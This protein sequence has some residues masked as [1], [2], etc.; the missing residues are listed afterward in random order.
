MSSNDASLEVLSK[1]A[2]AF[3]PGVSVDCVIFGFHDG[4]MKVL[5]NRFSGYDKWMIPGGFVFKDE[6]VDKAA[7]RILAGRTGLEDIYLRQF[8]FFGNSNR[9]DIDENKDMLIKLGQ[10]PPDI[11]GDTHWLLNRFISAGYYAL[12]EYSKVRIHT[13]PSEEIEWFAMDEIPVLYSDH[14]KIIDKAISTIRPQLSSI[15]VGYELLPE[16][17][18][19]SELRII[20]ETIL[21][22]ELDRRNFQRKILSTGL[23][24]K[25]DEM[26]KKWGFKSS[27]LFSFDKEKYMEAIENGFPLF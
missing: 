26:H 4:N 6:D 21:G 27:T 17:F 5:L 13:N 8:H 19:I 9:T 11:K 18:T 12:V 14:N 23:V 20:Y 22:K 15:P 16:K 24:I 2:E 10:L 3:L 25:L 7:L 1:N